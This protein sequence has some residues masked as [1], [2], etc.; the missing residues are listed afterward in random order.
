[1]VFD[2]PKAGGVRMS[3]DT[4]SADGPANM[5]VVNER[6]SRLTPGSLCGPNLRE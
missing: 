3:A 2:A 1:M 6:Y 5:C 4:L